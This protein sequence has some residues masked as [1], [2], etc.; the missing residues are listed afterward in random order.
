M[1]KHYTKSSLLCISQTEVKSE[2]PLEKKNSLRSL[3]LH[4]QIEQKT[5]ANICEIKNMFGGVLH[6]SRDEIRRI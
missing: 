2:T 6:G 5:E 3:F 4:K 1:G